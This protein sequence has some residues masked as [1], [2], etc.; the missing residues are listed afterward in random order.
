MVWALNAG[1]KGW[2]A[3]LAGWPSAR[4]SARTAAMRGNMKVSNPAG[5][6]G[7]PSLFALGVTASMV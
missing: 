1:G 2:T 5:E 4:D 6:A 3:A 7:W